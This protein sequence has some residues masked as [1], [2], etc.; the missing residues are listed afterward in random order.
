M[1]CIHN[2]SLILNDKLKNDEKEEQEKKKWKMFFVS[3]SHQTQRVHLLT[4]FIN[5]FVKSIQSSR[6]KTTT[7]NCEII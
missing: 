7:T 3:M 2:N 6:Y 5:L 4:K 1:N